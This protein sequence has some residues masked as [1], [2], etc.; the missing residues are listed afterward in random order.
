MAKKVLLVIIIVFVSIP[1]VSAQDSTKMKPNDDIKNQIEK[2]IEDGYIRI[3]KNDFD[4]IIENK[5]SKKV[6]ERFNFSLVIIG[7]IITTFGAVGAYAFRVMIKNTVAEELQNQSNR[8]IEDYKFYELDGRLR[9]IT[10]EFDEFTDLISTSSESAEIKRYTEKQN[11]LVPECEDLLLEITALDIKQL[12]VNKLLSKV[13]DQLTYMYYTTLVADLPKME[14]L[15][16][17]YE[18]KCDIPVTTYTN[19]AI[20]YKEL[21]AKLTD[22]EFKVKGLEHCKKASGKQPLYGDSRGTELLFYAIDFYNNKSDEAKKN[23]KKLL[24]KI[25]KN[26]PLAKHTKSRIDIDRRLYGQYIDNLAKELKS[27]FEELDKIGQA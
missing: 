7:V 17:E 2:V 22:D 12:K 1:Y 13:I 6:D 21:Y 4:E 19:L 25:L 24:Q 14:K 11:D 15:I 16:K 18:P 27:E 3:P 20:L 8:Y 26:E 9:A 23:A 5:I 10:K